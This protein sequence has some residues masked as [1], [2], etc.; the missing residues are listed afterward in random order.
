MIKVAQYHT[1]IVEA[2][3]I[4]YSISALHSI[5]ENV[6][7]DSRLYCLD[8]M[9]RSRAGPDPVSELLQPDIRSPRP[10]LTI[11]HYSFHDDIAV[12]L[13]S[14]PGRKIFVYHN[15]TPGYFF[16]REDMPGMAGLAAACNEGRA[17]LARLAPLIEASVGVSDYNSDELRDVGFRNVRTIPV[18]VNTDYFRSDVLDMATFETIRGGAATNIAFVGRF[19]PN[20]AIEDVISVLARYKQMFGPDIHLHL[21]GK[22]WDQAYY[23]SLMDHAARNNVIDLVRTYIG[24][25]QVKLKTVFNAVDALVSMSRH[26]GFMVPVVEAFAAGC[27]VIARAAGA[28]AETMGEGGFLLPDADIDCAAGL[29]RMLK[30]NGDLRDR[31]IAGQRR[32]AFDFR[33]EKTARSWLGML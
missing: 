12:Q 33:A 10:D 2:D 17:Q 29:I 31:V 21:I 6:G 32:R 24:L 18:F 3:A 25:E 7:L 16:E 14:L 4:G 20:K 11:I 22:I 8:H 23:A 13:A 28:V 9:V 15:I 30:Q 19:V 26:E 27:P 5:F 1:S